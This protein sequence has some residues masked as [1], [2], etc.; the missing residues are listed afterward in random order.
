MDSSTSSQSNYQQYSPVN[1]INLVA[2]D[3]EEQLYN[4]PYFYVGTGSGY[5]AEGYP[6]QEYSMGQGSGHGSY[7]DSV[8][9]DDD[10]D[11]NTLSE[12]MSPET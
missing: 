7:H 12:E 1:R 6:S 5:P 9:N 3:F 10:D 8:P 4:N 11:D 2:C